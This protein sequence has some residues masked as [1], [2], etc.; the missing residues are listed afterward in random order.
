MIGRILPAVLPILMLALGLPPIC[1]VTAVFLRSPPVA[2][3]PVAEVTT[4]G[5]GVVAAMA[6]VAA[7]IQG[8]R[9]GL[10]K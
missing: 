2:G 1:A 6:V 9:Q 10:G 8:A 4:I 7:A 5:C 3:W